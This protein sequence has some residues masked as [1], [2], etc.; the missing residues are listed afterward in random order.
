MKNNVAYEL[1]L[2]LRNQIIAARDIIQ[3]HLLNSEIYIFGS[4][5]K[6]KYSKHSDIDILILIK[7]ELSTK[8]LRKIKHFIEDSIEEIRIKREV[9]VKIYCKSRFL[10]LTDIPSFEREIMKDL[11]DIRMW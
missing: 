4:I 11:I 2:E 9:D 6:G 7:E 3:K 5:A 1:D 8:D 10:L